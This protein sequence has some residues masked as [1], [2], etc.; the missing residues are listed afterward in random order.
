MRLPHQARHFSAVS[1]TS[2]EAGVNL[3]GA[4]LM[5]AKQLVDIP[6]IDA[7][8]VQSLKSG[9]YMNIIGGAFSQCASLAPCFTGLTSLYS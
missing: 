7:A 9:V 3:N 8:V 4:D 6:Q 2:S 5:Q 1:E